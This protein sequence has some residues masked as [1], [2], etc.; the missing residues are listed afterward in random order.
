[1]TGAPGSRWVVELAVR[2][3]AAAARARG[4]ARRGLDPSDAA[5][6]AGL[7]ADTL[8]RSRRGQ[9]LAVALH[10][11]AVTLDLHTEAPT[12]STTRAAGAARRQVLT[13]LRAAGGTP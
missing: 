4:A 8:A 11:E 2:Y 12:P 5:R 6:V 9:R 13:A 3:R 10:T 1:M 7:I